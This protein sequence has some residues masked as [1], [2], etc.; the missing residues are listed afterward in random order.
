MKIIYDKDVDARYKILTSKKENAVE[1]K[2]EW[3]AYF[4]FSENDRLI[5]I[6]IL[7][8]SQ[9]L[10]IKNLK[11]VKFERVDKKKK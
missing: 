11:K 5:D 4:D 8:A 2:N 6:E 3:L 10:D 7:Q 9:L 1:A